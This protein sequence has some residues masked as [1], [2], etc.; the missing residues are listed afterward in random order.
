MKKNALVLWVTLAAST[1]CER[2]AEI[3]DWKVLEANPIATVGHGAILDA[4]GNQVDTTPSFLVEA[5]RYYLKRLYLQANEELRASF[6]AEQRRVRSAKDLTTEGQL[7]VNAGLLKW[8]IDRVGPEDA[9]YLR[10]INSALE[11]RVAPMRSIPASPQRPRGTA[12]RSPTGLTGS[13]YL[14]AWGVVPSTTRRIVLSRLTSA[15]TLRSPTSLSGAAYMAA[16]QSAGVPTPPDWGTAQW[17]SRGTLGQVFISTSSTAEVFTYESANPRGICF[18]LPRS[19]GNTI[20]LLGIICQGND[21]GKSCYWD[22]QSN[23]NSF[24][25]AKNTIVPIASFAGG[26]D[27]EGGS[28]GVCTD[29]HAG[30]NP[31]IV[32]PGSPLDRGPIMTPN[33][34]NDPLAPASWPQNA[35]PTTILEGI[36]LSPGDGSCL[37]CHGQSSGRRFPILSTVLPGYCSAVVL[38][39]INKTMPSAQNP[40]YAKHADAVKAWCARHPATLGIYTAVWQP[41]T[42]GEIQVFGWPYQDFRAKYDELW[43][44]GWRLKLL[45]THIV[46]G[47]VRYTAVWRPST[48]PEIQVYEFSY[49]NFKAKNDSLWSQGW[50]LKLLSTP[51]VGGQVRYTAVWQPSTEPDIQEYGLS[52][53]TFR[54]IYDQRWPIGWRLKLLSTYVV[55]G[56]VRYSAVWGLNTEGEIQVYGWSYPDFKTKYDE[57]WP[58]GWRLK[59]LSTYVDGGQIR[60]TAVWRPSTDGE[61]QEYSRPYQ[62]VRAK[63]DELWPQGWRLKLLTPWP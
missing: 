46:E 20:S 31:F 13:T 6:K 39:A 22:N 36:A 5:Q 47:N 41:S 49:P 35:G 48:E 7:L 15:A 4:Q 24:P 25:I 33:K 12:V 10:S 26:A 57:L 29:C 54:A 17:I 8:L 56:Q 19:S 3:E 16:C 28:G 30:N 61:I 34:W 9:T 38:N 45:S 23:K 14:A 21:V 1:A 18:A 51:V 11:A 2:S 62:N 63:Y 44:Q 40:A 58:Q 52:Y 59:L 27:L 42:E 60:Y 55:G 43:P 53:Q 37:A 50:R 32:H